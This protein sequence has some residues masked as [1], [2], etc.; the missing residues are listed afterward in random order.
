MTNTV[1]IESIAAYL[2]QLSPTSQA[3]IQQLSETIQQLVPDAQACIS[4]QIPAF[5]VGKTFI[6]FAA[7]KHHIGI[8][9][10]VT[11]NKE[12]IEKLGPYRNKKGN[13]TFP[14]NKPM[15]LA[16]I[17]EVVLAL[18]KQYITTSS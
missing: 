7:F 2:E 1:K 17:Q 9:P 13:L 16:L 4:Y 14:L 11:N 8:Y 10:P 3:V 6:Y 12:L 5:K 18:H 15:P